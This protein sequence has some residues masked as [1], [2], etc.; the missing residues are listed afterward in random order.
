MARSMLQRRQDA[1]RERIEAYDAR[2][3]Q[4][5]AATRPVPDFE[6]ALDDARSGF[7]GVAIRDGAL[8]CPK[9]KTRD[10]A[11]LRLAAARY[12]YARYPVSAALESVW[13]DSTGLDADEIALRKSWYVTVARG[14]SL[15][16]AGANAWLS[17]KEVHCFL[18]ASGDVGFAEA[19]WLA[20]ARSYTDDKGLAA[21]LART[22]IARTPRR[23]LAFWREVVRFFCG[24]PASKEEI[25]DLCDYIGAMHQRDTAYS[26]KG[27]TLPSLRRQMLDWHRDIAAIERIEAMR[28]RAAGRPQRGAGTQAERGAWD[29]SRLEDWEW[30][31]SAKEAK[32]RGERFF[33]RQLKTAEDLVAESRAMHHCVSTYAA[34]CIAGNASI[35]VLRRTALGKI[36]RLLTIEVDPQ[37]RAVQVRGFG[38]RLALPE[39]RKIIE[40]WAK[41]RGVMLRA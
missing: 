1:E 28:R 17:R 38:N 33:V 23:E 30:Q 16:K 29:G 6:R 2:L 3:R 13:L 11:R 8:W 4:V 26:L 41:A 34:K 22:K 32:V 12:L 19:F 9:L 5:F 14:D 18:N 35:W 10:R 27:R 37:N 40:R 20:I 15:Y 36:E 39:E 25:D 24:H 7:A 31:P 21:R